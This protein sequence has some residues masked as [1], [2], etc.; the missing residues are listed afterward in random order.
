MRQ[1]AEGAAKFV[2]L[3]LGWAAFPATEAGLG[4]LSRC[5]DTRLGWRCRCVDARLRRRIESRR[6]GVVVSTGLCGLSRCVGAGC[7]GELRVED[8]ES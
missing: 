7:V 3:P 2:R 5:R 6:H 8:V 1:R 4:C